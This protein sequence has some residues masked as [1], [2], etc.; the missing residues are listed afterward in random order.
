MIKQVLKNQFP[1]F[2]GEAVTKTEAQLNAMLLAGAFGLGG[3]AIDINETSINNADLPSGFYYVYP[4]SLGVLPSNVSYYMIYLDNSAAAH[5]MRLFFNSDGS[6]YWRQTKIAGAWQAQRLHRDYLNSP[7]QTTAFDT[8][9][10]ALLTPASFG[11]GISAAAGANADLNWPPFAEVGYNGRWSGFSWVN[12]PAG[13][14]ATIAVLELTTYS[15]DWAQQR[16]IGIS[17]G[18]EYTRRW[19]SGTT[20]STWERVEKVSSETLAVNGFRVTGNYVEQWGRTASIGDDVTLAVPFNIA[21]AE[22]F[23]IVATPNTFVTNVTF[24]CPGITSVQPLQF[25]LTN[26]NNAGV[27]CQFFWRATG[28]L[29]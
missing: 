12:C 21:M 3:P 2:T 19:H 28:R 7:G 6:T 9:G 8:T 4:A 24:I 15:P 13:E 1:A 5:A 18:Q 20:W 16:F 22:C 27:S 10:T 14:G 26:M 25:S 17:T 29:A 23:N 11:I